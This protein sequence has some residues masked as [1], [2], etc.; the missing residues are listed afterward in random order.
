MGNKFSQEV[1]YDGRGIRGIMWK[2]IHSKALI[3]MKRNSHHVFTVW[4][5]FWFFFA[6]HWQIMLNAIL[7]NSTALT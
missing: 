7:T 4:L 3:K 1:L 5:F 6:R 2:N